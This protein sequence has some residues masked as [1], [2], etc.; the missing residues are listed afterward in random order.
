MYD[1]VSVSQSAIHKFVDS[2]NEYQQNAIDEL[3]MIDPISFSNNKRVDTALNYL[4]NSFSHVNSKSKIL[5]RLNSKNPLIKP[6]A[7][8]INIQSK[9]MLNKKT[10]RK[11]WLPVKT[12]LQYVP[13][14]QVLKS[15]LELPNVFE[16]ILKSFQDA[17]HD[18]PLSSFVQGK[19]WRNIQLKYPNKLLIPLNIF[20]DDFEID[21]PLGSHEKKINGV[22]YTIGC[23]PPQY[24]SKLENWFLA[25]FHPEE[26]FKK[27]GGQIVF[28][29]LKEQLLQLRDHGIVIKVGGVE[30]RVFF[31]VGRI[32]GDNLGMNQML[33]FTTSFNSTYSCRICLADSNE[34]QI[35]HIEDPALLRNEDNYK[36]DVE[37]AEKTGN[38][39]RGVREKSVSHN[40]YDM[41][42]N[43]PK[44]PLHDEEE[45]TW[46]K[47]L[48]Q[49]LDNFIHDEQINFTLNDLNNSSKLLNIDA[50]CGINF[51]S[52][53]SENALDNKFM[54]LSG[55]EMRFMIKYLGILIGKYIP[56]GNKT[57]QL[58]ILH[59]K[60]YFLIMS[61][62]Y[63][64]DSAHQLR[65]L[66]SQ[67]R[68][69]YLELGY[70]PLI[71]KHHIVNHCPSGVSDGP[72]RYASGIRGE[73]IHRDRKRTANATIS[74]KNSL[75]TLA[76]RYQISLA[77][78]FYE[79]KP[80][81]SFVSFKSKKI[82]E[83]KE[84]D[85]YD[86]FEE[87]S[88]VAADKKN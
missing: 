50:A 47:K 76:M 27:L 54:K 60:I 9:P 52:E 51:P 77:K 56:R 70:G 59:R 75:Y 67:H 2:I 14:E 46:K 82:I 29:K 58:Y 80:L 5:K 21:N 87:I 33:C 73:A 85:N 62:S 40:I 8:L 84:L 32:L 17:Q 1:N 23:L 83:F 15:F 3:R 63:T 16:T 65:D 86:K 31:H 66:I 25:Q 35:Q 10:G 7:R 88:P 48:P 43:P 44:D 42:E 74:R 68:K 4:K 30:R 41:F 22:Y 20:F 71:C 55:S 72:L 28:A 64:E 24:A 36:K 53:V 34:C 49:Y 12:Y 39:S 69:L 37:T 11:S 38:V 26:D 45:G 19:Y 78:R 18:Y 79:G 61:P 6:V 13:M 81:T 57:W